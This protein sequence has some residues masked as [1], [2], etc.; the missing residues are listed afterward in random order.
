MFRGLGAAAKPAAMYSNLVWEKT[1]GCCGADGVMLCVFPGT[2]RCPCHQQDPLWDRSQ[3]YPLVS[4]CYEPCI[5]LGK[6]YYL[7]FENSL[8]CRYGRSPISRQG[9]RWY[10]RQTELP[11]CVVVVPSA[12]PSQTGHCGQEARILFSLGPQHLVP[13]VGS[14]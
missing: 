8:R 4:I 12:C 1:S 13:W 14:E 5:K 9:V 10:S 7:I 3:T 6:H 11:L 2:P